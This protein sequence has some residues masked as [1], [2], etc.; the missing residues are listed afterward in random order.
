MHTRAAPPLP[1]LIR[2]KKYGQAGGN[3]NTQDLR[4]LASPGENSCL[5]TV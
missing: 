4:W 3:E 1:F 2:K 5:P